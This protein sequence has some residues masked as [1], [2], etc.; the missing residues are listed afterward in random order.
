MIT[1]TSEPDF[2][3]NLKIVFNFE[4]MLFYQKSLIKTPFLKSSLKINQAKLLNTDT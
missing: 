2:I 3:S 4:N 1:K